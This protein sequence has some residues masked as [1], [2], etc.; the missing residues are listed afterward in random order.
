VVSEGVGRVGWTGRAGLGRWTW[1][2]VCMADDGEGRWVLCRSGSS[3]DGSITVWEDAP[4]VE[5]WEK[6]M[7]FFCR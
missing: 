5:G 1:C 4:S 2:W 6:F 3:C 7:E